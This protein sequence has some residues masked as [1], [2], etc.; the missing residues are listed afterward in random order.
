[1]IKPGYIRETVKISYKIRK[2][3]KTHYM[4]F[5]HDFEIFDSEIRNKGIKAG[6]EYL[7]ALD[8]T[9]KSELIKNRPTTETGET[10]SKISNDD[11]IRAWFYDHLWQPIKDRLLSEKYH[12][13]TRVNYAAS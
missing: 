9:T 2:S 10:L 1:M 11:Y 7:K 8:N 6:N 12:K 3:T 4:E 13:H 5:E